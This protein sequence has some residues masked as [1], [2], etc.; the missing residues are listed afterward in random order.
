MVEAWEARY[1]SLAS[2]QQKIQISKCASPEM[3]GDYVLWKNLAGGAEFLDLVVLRDSDMFG[4]L[5]P[6]RAELLEYL[7]RNNVGSIRN[8]ASALHR[9]YKNVYDD[10][11]ALAKYE[12]VELIP[13]GRSLRPAAAA[14]RIN[15]ALDE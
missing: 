14:S 8:L 9:N 1:G 6:R 7:L 3:M 5:S 2:L 10:L 13:E 4:T 11:L 15:I 12:L